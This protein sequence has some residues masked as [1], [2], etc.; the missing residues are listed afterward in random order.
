M[1][2]HAQTA[3]SRARGGRKARTP[4]PVTHADQQQLEALG[5]RLF[6]NIEDPA[7]P[8]RPY[9][10]VNKKMQWRTDLYATAQLAIDAARTIQHNSKQKGVAI[11]EPEPDARFAVGS[12]APDMPYDMTRSHPQPLGVPLTGEEMIQKG[13]ELDRVLSKKEEIERNFDR[14]KEQFKADLKDAEAAVAEVE[15]VLRKQADDAEVQVEERL[16]PDAK[17]VAEV[18]T[19]TGVIVNLRPMKPEEGT[20]PLLVI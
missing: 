2:S 10:M 12:V 8:G 19:D 17:V 13:I 3:R 4:Q 1:S 15:R 9:Q 16:Y 20:R 18:R 14:V 6:E 7:K 5:W 11:T